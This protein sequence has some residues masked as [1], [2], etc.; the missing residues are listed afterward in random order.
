MKQTQNTTSTIRCLAWN[1]KLWKLSFGAQFHFYVCPLEM[2]ECGDG[3]VENLHVAEL[4]IIC[5]KTSTFSTLAYFWDM[6]SSKKKK[7][8]IKSLLQKW[9]ALGGKKHVKDSDNVTEGVHVFPAENWVRRRQA[10][11]QQM[12]WI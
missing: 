3:P 6:L 5:R 11:G 7:K 9:V 1:K 8:K 12:Y 10:E 2:P 4:Q